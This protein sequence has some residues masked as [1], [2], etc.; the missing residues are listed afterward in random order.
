MWRK[1]KE[2]ETILRFEEIIAEKFPN[3]RKVCG[4]FMLS[5]VQL[6]ATPWTVACQAPLSVDILQARI[7]EWV[8]ISSSRGSSPPRDWTCVSCIGRQILYHWATWESQHE[9][10][11][12]QVW[13]EQ[14]VSNKM[15]PR[16]NMLRH[17]LIKLTKIKD[18]QKILKATRKKQQIR[19]KGISKMLSAILSR[20]TL[21]AITEEHDIFKV[22]KGKKLQPRKLYP[23]SL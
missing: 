16:R 6:F 2:F 15:N 19:Y 1:E 11:N 3:M 18:K 20:E 9:K 7:L 5:H 22:M 12:T 21:Q 13:E 4:T 17:I 14:K 8:S 10:G 23:E